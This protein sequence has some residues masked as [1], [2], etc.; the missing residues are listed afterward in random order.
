VELLTD[1][2]REIIELVADGRQNIEVAGL[3]AISPATVRKHLEN[4]Y[5]KLGVHTRTGAA[6]AIA[7]G[8]ERQW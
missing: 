6:A 8:R 2:E 5:A 3:L 4:A 1:R 7:G